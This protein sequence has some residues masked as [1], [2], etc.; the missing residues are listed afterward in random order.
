M[1]KYNNL[2][3]PS[4]TEGAGF[5]RFNM[6]NYLIWQQARAYDISN[7]LLQSP[8][9]D[10]NFY[11]NFDSIM[12]QMQTSEESLK[13]IFFLR[14]IA[15]QTGTRLIY[16]TDDVMYGPDIP[17]YNKGKI[18]YMDKKLQSRLKTIFDLC[19]Y[20]VV[21]TDKI[22]EYYCQR[23]NLPSEKVIR[24]PNLLP[25]W[26]IGGKYNLN[27]SVE[28]FKSHRKNGKIRVGI[29]S[30]GSH[31]NINENRV[32]ANGRCVM[33]VSVSEK[34]NKWLDEDLK[35]VDGSYAESLPYA[36]DDMDTILDA[37][38]K[39][40]DVVQWVVVGQKDIR[41]LKKYGDKIQYVG[42]SGI[43]HYPHLVNTC[44]LDAI[45]VPCKKDEIFN[46]C[47]SNIKWLECCALGIPAYT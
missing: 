7:S 19:D 25:R 28:K 2:I 31:W 36:T 27:Y 11:I 41:Q 21:T 40:I 43:M 45:V 8:V 15:N 12:F 22:K 46:Q 10:P 26:W 17:F 24:I 6:A 9:S 30:S 32:D 42:G 33:K 5:W 4:D 23:Y 37:I 1:A 20:V 39:T 35:E 47:K 3:I 44:Q 16:N 14:N 34:E 18:G 13:Y 38:D 29:I